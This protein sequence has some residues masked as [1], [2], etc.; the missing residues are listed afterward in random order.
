MPR[1]L[2]DPVDTRRHSRVGR[3][4]SRD[5][6]MHRDALVWQQLVEHGL[7]QQRVSKVVART[8]A[9]C[10]QQAPIH[11]RARRTT[12]RDVIEPRG[13]G[14]PCLR[15][16]HAHNRGRPHKVAAGLIQNTEARQHEVTNRLGN[17]RRTERGHELLDEQWISV[18]VARDAPNVVRARVRAEQDLG[19]LGGR[20]LREWCECDLVRRESRQLRDQIALGGRVL[21]PVGDDEQDRQPTQIVRD[22][23]DQLTAGGIDPVQVVDDENQPRA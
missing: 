20:V 9:A 12:R 18:G 5:R 10:D 22:V 23:P 1:Q 6:A 4:R 19:H 21:S 14:E 16:G 13:R 2:R 15:C 17:T 8:V 3:Q 7:A 11:R